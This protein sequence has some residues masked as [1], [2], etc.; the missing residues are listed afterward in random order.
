MLGASSPAVVENLLP[1]G[2]D[3]YLRLFHPFV[4]R[5]SDP[6]DRTPIV[7]GPTWREMAHQAGVAFVGTLTYR[8]IESV[9]PG[10]DWRDCPWALWEGELEEG[11]ARELFDTLD[12]GGDGPWLF[13]FG[14][15]AI[16]GSAE[17]RPLLFSTPSPDHRRAVVDAARRSGATQLT[18][19][20]F[21]HPVDRRW[22]TFTDYDLA[23]TYL[24]TSIEMAH[25]L[26]ANES[27]EIVEVQLDT[28]VDDHADEQQL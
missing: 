11:T 5:G 25:R 18:T 12:D 26:L 6:A 16:I 22:I 3:R 21:V 1:R 20:E 28:R 19:A 4:A 14:L 15:A 8:Q 2:F 13:G 17:H 23:S 27:L 7:H 9:L 24:A 10:T